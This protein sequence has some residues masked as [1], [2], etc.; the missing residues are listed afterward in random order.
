VYRASLT[1]TVVLMVLARVLTRLLDSA[2]SERVYSYRKGR[3]SQQAVRDL[4]ALVKRHTAQ[5]REP[6]QRGL[7]V[8]RRDVAGYGDN[9]PVHEGSPL[10]PALTR[11]LEAA[12]CP[13][14]HP[15]HALLAQALRPEIVRLNGETE[16]PKRG[17]PMGSPLQPIICNF[18]LSELDQEL[19]ALP[20]GYYA[21]F[22][23]DLL[24][25]HPEPAPSAEAALAIER[26]LSR[27][28]LELNVGKSKNVYWNG[29]GRLPDRPASEGERGATHIE[30]LGARLSFAGG[31]MLSVRKL[32][33]T[34]TELHTRLRASERLLRDAPREQRVAALTS[35]LSGALDP[36][37]EVAVPLA[38]ELLGLGDDRRELKQLDHW[39][40]LRLA[41]V[42]SGQHGVRAFR[43]IS[44]RR[45]REHGLLSL[46]RRRDRGRVLE[47]LRKE[48]P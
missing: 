9:I 47:T 46:L 28:G 48:P 10:W 31:I 12:D 29:A 4:A 7:H 18:Y 6:R 13:A 30:Y 14:Q 3:S 23:D 32:R 25:L 36:A 33:R 27:L 41:E 8:V 42:L 38:S 34:R 11:A 40:A 15:L 21:R 39:L 44:Y 2:L 1:D 17:V 26:R 43:S 24:F 37:S 19:S 20:G 35:A 16:R 22:G 45:L 5:R